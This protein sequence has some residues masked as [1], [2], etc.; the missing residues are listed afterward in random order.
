MHAAGRARR[1]ARADREASVTGGGV[2]YRWRLREVMAQR[3]MFVTADLAPALAAHG[4]KLSDSQ[5]WRLITGRPE[6]LNLRVLI[7]LCEILE[8]APGDLIERVDAAPAKK[9][10]T[11][12]AAGAEIVPRRARVKRDA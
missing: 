4:V 9:R 7:V 6:R 11:G 8:C 2:D 3:G 10:A 5:V 12:R 1:S